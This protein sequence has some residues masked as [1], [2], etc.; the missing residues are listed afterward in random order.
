MQA[1]MTYLKVKMIQHLIPEVNV[2]KEV[3]NNGIKKQNKLEE[4]L[5]TMR[6]LMAKPAGVQ[7]SR[8]SL[9]LPKK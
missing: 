3:A 8:K 2:L 7:I 6:G 1:D 5:D 9:R 4:N